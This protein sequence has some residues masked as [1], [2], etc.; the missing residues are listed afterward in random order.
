[1][2]FD[3]CALRKNSVWAF[4][5]CQISSKKHSFVMEVMHYFANKFLDNLD[6]LAAEILWKIGR[7]KSTTFHENS[8]LLK[9]I[10][11]YPGA[12]TPF[13]LGA[14]KRLF[15]HMM[16]WSGTSI[17]D[18]ICSDINWIFRRWAIFFFIFRLSDGAGN[19]ARE[20]IHHDRRYNHFS[21]MTVAMTS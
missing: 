1:M 2:T 12:D 17:Y 9:E 21:E 8:C 4:E 16:L 7:K 3:S 18:W 14:A 19:N 13:F 20:T 6:K 11:Q 10:W 15:L 5:Y